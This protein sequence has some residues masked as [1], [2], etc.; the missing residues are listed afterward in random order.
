MEEQTFLIVNGL[1]VK[2]KMSY[3]IML[4]QNAVICSKTFTKFNMSTS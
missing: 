2:I 4:Y 3:H 1:G